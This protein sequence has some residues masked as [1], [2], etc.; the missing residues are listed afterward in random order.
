[1]YLTFPAP[2]KNGAKTG[3]K[4]TVNALVRALEVRLVFSHRT[5]PNHRVGIQTQVRACI[6]YFGHRKKDAKTGPVRALN[7][8]VRARNV[9][10]LL[11]HRTCP[12]H[13]G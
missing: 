11:S 4:G 2:T 12:N 10:L 7:A 8:L 6:L 9:R 5:C 1:M 13:P 3:L